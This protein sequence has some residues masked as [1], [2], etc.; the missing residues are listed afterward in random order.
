MNFILP[1][2]E[3][4]KVELVAHQIS[5]MERLLA[6]NQNDY[7]ELRTDELCAFLL[8]QVEA[9]QGTIKALYEGH[10]AAMQ[11][12]AMTSFDWFCALSIASGAGSSVPP[13]AAATICRKM[14]AS[15]KADP[16]YHDLL[17]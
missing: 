2:A 10:A 9:L 16:D 11:E 13:L 6:Q 1:E 5:L 15:T 17:K 3:F 12:G 4:T 14:A 7:L 8:A